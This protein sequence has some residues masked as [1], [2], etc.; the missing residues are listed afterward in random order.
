M[1]CQDVGLLLSQYL[2]DRQGEILVQGVCIRLFGGIF[3]ILCRCQQSVIAAAKFSFQI[4]PNA[5][6][7]AGSGSGFIDIMNS[8][9]MENLFEI[10]AK[11]RSLQGF[12]KKVPLEGLILQVFAYF[13]ESLLAIDESADD[14]SQGKMHLIALV[15][16][17]GHAETSFISMYLMSS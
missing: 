2:A 4:P 5:V 15:S 10:A 11:A 7:G 8:I 6:N 13:R 17:G 16:V 1:C 12:G 3:A 9:L 14:S